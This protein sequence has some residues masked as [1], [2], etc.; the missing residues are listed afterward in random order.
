MK[1]EELWNH[2]LRVVFL[3]SILYGVPLLS[4][5]ILCPLEVVSARL[6]I[7]RTHDTAAIALPP[8]LTED[9]R[10]EEVSRYAVGEDDVVRCVRTST[11]QGRTI[12]LPR[13]SV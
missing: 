13:L 2:K 4:A 7:Q 3:V 12:L 10:E 6:S 5:A 11:P 9:A 8:T 1:P